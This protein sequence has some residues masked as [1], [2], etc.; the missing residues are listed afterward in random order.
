MDGA[1]HCAV[2]VPGDL[3][4]SNRVTPPARL[5]RVLLDEPLN[6]PVEQLHLPMS[7]EP[8]VRRITDAL[9][10]APGDRSTLPEWAQRL[11]MSERSLARLMRRETGLS[12]GRW[13]QQLQ[14]LVA[15]RELSGGARV[16]QVAAELGYE[17]VTAFITMFKKA[18]GQ[19]P[20]RYLA[21]LTR[22]RPG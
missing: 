7:S 20:A 5:A 1:A 16:Q 21:A 8:R 14:L 22:E 6:M 10:R 19:P 9:L 13:R 11:A 2:W 18:L 4:H 15:L 3:P 12:F 17:S